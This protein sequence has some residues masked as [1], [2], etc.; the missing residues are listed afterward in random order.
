MEMLGD[1]DPVDL[2]VN[3]S[4]CHASIRPAIWKRLRNN[5]SDRRRRYHQRV[6]SDLLGRV[7]RAPTVIREQCHSALLEQSWN[8]PATTGSGRLNRSL[9]DFQARCEDRRATPAQLLR[10]A[11]LPPPGAGFVP[12]QAPAVASRMESLLLRHS[13]LMISRME[14]RLRRRRRLETVSTPS[15]QT[16][17]HCC[18]V[19]FPP[20]VKPPKTGWKPNSLLT[21]EDSHS[22]TRPSTS[23]NRKRSS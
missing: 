15:S 10:S 16:P 13:A 22:S 2:E 6:W 12:Q 23:G 17:P 9:R 21:P 1:D 8:D 4:R 19:R 11:S 7:E 20:G 3:F 14:R 5:P 18:A